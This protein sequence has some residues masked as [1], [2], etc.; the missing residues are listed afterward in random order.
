MPWLPMYCQ[1]AAVMPGRDCQAGALEI[2]HRLL[3]G[4]AADDHP[5]CHGSPRGARTCV[6]KRAIG[7]PDWT[8]SVSSSR[9]S[10]ST[11]TMRSNDVQSRAARA[12][13]MYTTRSSGRSAFS[14]LFS[15][16]RRMVS[17]LQ[18]RQ[19]SAVPRAATT[20]GRVFTSSVATPTQQ[21]RHEVL[22]S[23]VHGANGGCRDSRRCADKLLP[24]IQI[25]YQRS[26]TPFGLSESKEYCRDREADA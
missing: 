17:C 2:E 12:A 6:R 20:R 10:L 1:A 7:L 13:D 4:P 5:V 25:A 16:S 8:T 26:R 11:A 21:L 9:R 19:R 14:R 24:M 22:E 3:V 23:M 15:S 18:P